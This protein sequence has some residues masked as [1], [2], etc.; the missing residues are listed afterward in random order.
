MT[1]NYK[2]YHTGALCQLLTQQFTMCLFVKFT[3]CY[4]SF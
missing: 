2:D 4:C 3:L 1:Y